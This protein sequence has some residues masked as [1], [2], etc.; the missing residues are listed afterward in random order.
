MCSNMYYQIKSCNCFQGD[1][2]GTNSSESDYKMHNSFANYSSHN[3]NNNN[4]YQNRL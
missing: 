3:Y 2:L 1:A 4:V